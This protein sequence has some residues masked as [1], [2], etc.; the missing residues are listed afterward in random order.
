MT[1]PPIPP[2]DNLYK[3][4]A[5][6]GLIIVLLSLFIPWKLGSELRILQI[7][8]ELDLKRLEIDQESIEASSQ[9]T[10]DAIQNYDELMKNSDTRNKQRLESLNFQ[11]TDQGGRLKN[12]EL[13]LAEV[14]T[15][16]EKHQF[17]LLQFKIL[18]L[19]SWM[20]L[21]VGMLMTGLGFWNWYFK[22]QIYQ[23]RIVKAQARAVDTP[24]RKQEREELP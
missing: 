1:L 10:T 7:D 24:Q 17:L 18:G 4:T 5:I 23:D 13:F 11:L 22:F 2:S 6:S 15:A 9:K 19:I 21:M 20:A 12:H 16:N 3:F 8:I 14:K